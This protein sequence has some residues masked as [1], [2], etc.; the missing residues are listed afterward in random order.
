MYVKPTGPGETS[1]L[2][3]VCVSGGP[4]PSIMGPDPVV[5]T[6][7]DRLH[8][9]ILYKR[10]VGNMGPDRDRAGTVIN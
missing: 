10:P 7:K 6:A 8:T 1:M 3:R 5:V 9:I 4:G 2:R